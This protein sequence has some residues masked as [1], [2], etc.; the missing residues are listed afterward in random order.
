[1]HHPEDGA[2]ARR[3]MWCGKCFH[4]WEQ[5]VEDA[6]MCPKCNSQHSYELE[7]YEGDADGIMGRD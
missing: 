4:R 1:M 6:P 5:S 7:Q 2:I 3:L